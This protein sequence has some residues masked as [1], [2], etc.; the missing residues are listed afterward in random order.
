MFY[1]NVRADKKTKK[2]GI[3][4]LQPNS[5]DARYL[6]DKNLNTYCIKRSRKPKTNDQIIN[7]QSKIEKNDSEE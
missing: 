2:R 5:I 7:M 1:I 4:D 3:Y 6:E